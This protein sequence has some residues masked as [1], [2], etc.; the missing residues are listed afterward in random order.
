MKKLIITLALAFGALFAANAQFNSTKNLGLRLGWGVEASFQLPMK[1]SNR[2]EFDLGLGW[3]GG[4]YRGYTEFNATA[5]Y[6]WVFDLSDVFTDGFAWYVGPGVGIGV[7]S[8]DFVLGPVGQIGLEYNFKFPLQVA[9]DWRPGFYFIPAGPDVF[10][11]GW[12]GFCASA[13]YRF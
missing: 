13:R 7:W 2:F 1:E 10:N 5:V 12:E 3:G 4:N 9:V 8:K 11:F 6:H